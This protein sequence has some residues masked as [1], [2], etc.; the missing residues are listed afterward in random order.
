MAESDSRPLSA[1]TDISS[2]NE[3]GG[4]EHGMFERFLHS[5]VASSGVLVLFALLALILANSPWSAQYF[6]VAKTQLGLQLGELGYSHTLSHWI[7]DGLMAI[8]FF[9]VG[10]EIKRELVVGELSSVRRAALPVSAAMGGALVPALIYAWFN[11]SGPGA[12]GWGI[13]MATDIAFAL[14]VLALFGSR[15]PIGLK[16]FLTA[17]A[18]A[19]DLLAVL[20]IALFYTSTLNMAAILSAG[21]FLGLLYAV[22]RARVRVTL[23]YFVLSIGVW[24]SLEA[25][26]IHA[27]IAGV[28]IALIIPVRSLIEPKQFLRTTHENLHLLEQCRPTRESL[29]RNEEQRS[30]V[31]RI[32]LASQDM[33]PPGIALEQQLHVVQAFLVLPLFALVAAG[34]KLDPATLSQF[35]GSPAIGIMLGLVIGKQIGIMAASLLAVFTGA[36]SLPTGVSWRHIWAASVL[37]GIGFTMSIFI[38]DLA[39]TDQALIDEAKIAI[40]VAS[41]TAGAL[42][43]FLLHLFLPR[44]P[45][46][47][48]KDTGESDRPATQP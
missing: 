42:G 11:A 39:F 18:I 17:L 34:V 9:V 21:L 40:L 4:N 13:P 15:V 47:D 46:T 5:Q 19:D 33:I 30:A 48:R 25:S 12:A 35:P 16:V 45:G 41:L 6:A 20:V 1:P 29:N 27:T 10:L 36:A 24:T 31:S 38:A 14:G 7:K 26:G 22:S 2:P 28:L 3:N 37:A 32:Y 43:A 23:V 44:K 8:F